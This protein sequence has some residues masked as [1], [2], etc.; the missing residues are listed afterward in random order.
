MKSNTL[1]RILLI[2]ENSHLALALQVVLIE[3]GNKVRWERDSASATKAIRE[4]QPD[5]MLTASSS[6]VFIS[7]RNSGEI[8]ELPRPVDTSELRNILESRF[9]ASNP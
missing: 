4:F 7:N 2:M 3:L 6:A 8:V 9:V 1:K 5:V